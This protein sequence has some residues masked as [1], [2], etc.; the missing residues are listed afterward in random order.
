MSD[1]TGEV[2][3]RTGV[4]DDGSTRKSGRFSADLVGLY[5]LLTLNLIATVS[6]GILILTKPAD[7]VSQ[8]SLADSLPKGL[9]LDQ[10]NTTKDLLVNSYNNKDLD[11]LYEIFGEYAKTQVKK[12]DVSKVLTG[13]SGLGK[14]SATSFLNCEL[15]NSTD[16]GKWYRVKFGAMYETGN[17]ALSITYLLR[18][19]I[20][21]VIAYNFNVGNQ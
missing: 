14:I 3:G 21:E 19:G 2:V 20:F 17:G 5:F 13:I 6:F 10:L 9:T 18:N 16:I 7:G 1:T 11:S 15:T 8:P 4:D 12:E